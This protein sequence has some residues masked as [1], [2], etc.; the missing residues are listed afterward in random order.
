MKTMKRFLALLL[1]LAMTLSNLPVA[2]LA[3]E[4]TEL[5]TGETTVE[6]TVETPVEEPTEA[7]SEEETTAPS[8]EPTEAPSEAVIEE[9]FNPISAVLLPMRL[10]VSETACPSSVFT[11]VPYPTR[12]I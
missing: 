9:T 2:V 4:L 8:E 1:V 11:P 7:P 5:V 3:D 10:H 12:R 6:E